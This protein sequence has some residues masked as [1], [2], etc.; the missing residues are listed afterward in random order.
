MAKIILAA[1]QTETPSADI[2]DERYE[3]DFFIYCSVYAADIVN[4]QFQTEVGTWVNAKF[5]GDD[6]ELSGAG[7]GA[8]VTIPRGVP[9]RV[10]TANAGATVEI[11]RV[12]ANR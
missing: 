4:I 12:E 8:I 3:G 11:S 10:S 7:D 1:T 2:L 5:E 6:I 9:F